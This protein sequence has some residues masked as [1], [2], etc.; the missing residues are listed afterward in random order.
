[1]INTKRTISL[2]KIQNSKVQ[3]P[4]PQI[5]TPIFAASEK[6]VSDAEI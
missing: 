3:I 1:M 2:V 5:A 4:N 6:I